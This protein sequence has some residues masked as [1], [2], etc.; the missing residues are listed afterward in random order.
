MSANMKAIREREAD[1]AVYEHAE[2]VGRYLT[3]RMDPAAQRALRDQAQ[4]AKSPK[5][6]VILL[7]Q[8]ADQLGTVAAPVMA[9]KAGC[10]HCCY[11]PAMIGATEAAQIARETGAPMST[12]AY[13]YPPKGNTAFDGVACTF[14]VDGGCSIYANRPFACRIHFIVDRDNTLC[15]IVPGEDIQAPHLDVDNYHFS[16]VQA[17]GAPEM[18]Q[19][20]DVREFFP[21]G[22]GRKAGK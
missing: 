15:E 8:M 7:R 13:Q 18:R 20:A 1:P 2:K 17:F 14:L 5:T 4:R 3:E 10:S 21:Q 19:M 6:K 16:Y 22:L 11:M 12:P 9:C